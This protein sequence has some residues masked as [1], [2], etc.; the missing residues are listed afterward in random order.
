MQQTQILFLGGGEILKIGTKLLEKFAH[1]VACSG[2]AEHAEGV[3]NIAAGKHTGAG[4]IALTAVRA[5]D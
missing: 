5:K 2:I 4:F 3:L 1:P